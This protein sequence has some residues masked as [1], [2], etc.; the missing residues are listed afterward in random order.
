[1]VTPLMCSLGPMADLDDRKHM[2]E[3]K[4]TL[5]RVL[6]LLGIATAGGWFGAVYGDIL[7]HLRRT[8]TVY[9][10][11]ATCFLLALSRSNLVKSVHSETARVERL[12]VPLFLLALILTTAAEVVA[13]TGLFLSTTIRVLV[14][15][16][17]FIGGVSGIAIG[18]RQWPLHRSHGTHGPS[19][20]PN[21]P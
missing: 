9:M 15:V 10:L 2:R 12:A 20:G 17:A 19:P 6:V 18:S 14:G 21:G 5:H 16:I 4:S 1:M 11:A 3:R 7:G 8:V 13:M